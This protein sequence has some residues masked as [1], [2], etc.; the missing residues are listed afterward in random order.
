MRADAAE[1]DRRHEV[2]EAARS[3][4][5]AGAIDEATRKK[6]DELY[7]D[8]RHRLGPVFRVLVFCFTLVVVQSALGIVG[9]AFAAGGEMAG[10]LVFMLCGLGLAVLT[11]VQIGHL[12]RRQG[13]TE[14]AT[15]FLAV[16]ML[17]GTTFWL[18]YRVARPREDFAFNLALVLVM[19][20]PGLAAYRWGYALFAGLAAV[21]AF[22]L[23]GRFPFGRVLWVAAAL[24]LAPLLLRASDWQGLCP[25]HRRSCQTIAAVAL[26]FLYLAVH[27]GSWDLGLVE[28]LTGHGPGSPGMRRPYRPFFIAATAL[29]PLVTLVWGLRSRRRLPISLGLVG[30][31]ASVVT[32]RFY[33]HVAPLWVALTASGGAAI[34]L[35]LLV[36]RYLDSG[37]GRE[38]GGFTAEPV[39]TDPEGRSALEVAASV[40]SFSP[41][42][43]PLEQPGFQGGGGRSGGAGASGSF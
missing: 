28:T 34:G 3:W 19:L 38:R 6:I 14:S 37:P 1:A 22:V 18:F 42:P 11:E 10:I 33:V 39:F 12:R 8:D 40:A 31:L 41:A 16:T 43:R 20:V 32:L 9:L 26:A 15:A 29:V 30:V 35:A 36:R 2:R 21:A 27:L 23:L 17:I 13:G 24:P 25:S 4:Q 7:P 5:R